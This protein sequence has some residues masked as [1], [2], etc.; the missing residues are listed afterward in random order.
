ML[1]EKYKREIICFRVRR[2]CG[3][4]SFGHDQSAH[5]NARLSQPEVQR[6]LG[7]LSDV[8]RKRIGILYTQIKKLTIEG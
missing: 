2:Y 6:Q 4:I 7:L 5:A 1:Q 8:T 3:G